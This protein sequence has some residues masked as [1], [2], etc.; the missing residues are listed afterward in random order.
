MASIKVKFRPSTIEGKKGVIYYQVIQNRIIRQL[1]TNYH[2]SPANWDEETFT[3][4]LDA[5]APNEELATIDKQ[6]QWDVKRLEAIIRL[7]EKKHQAYSS[8]D[9]I[10]FFQTRAKELSLFDYMHIQIEKQQQ[11]GR[12]RTAETYTTTLYSISRY[13]HQEDILM[14]EITSDLLQDYEDSLH[15]Q[16]VSQNSS[17]FY[18]R[19]L[20]AVY[21]RSVDSGIIEQKYPFKEV[22]TGIDKTV[23]KAIPLDMIK[24]I[25][26]LDFSNNPHLLFARD[27]FL[28]SFYT[29]GMS[30]IDMAYLRKEDLQDDTLIYSRRKTGHKLFVKWEPCMQEIIDRHPSDPE[31]PYMLPILKAPFDNER[32]Q[33]KTCLFLVNKNLK[34]VAAAA[35]IPIPL[36]MFVAR[37]SWAS[38]ASQKN[39]P[40]SIIS[41]GMGHES[42]QDTMIYLASLDNTLVDKANSQILDDL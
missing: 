35:G 39:I 26:A 40:L 32:N 6:V 36:T 3:F 7:F 41:E 38:I 42:E 33:Y 5:D 17:S 30:F 1:K 29:R 21:N 34:I 27:M 14:E 16:G 37:H 25:K 24:A 18:M 23:K 28:F 20:R 10:D 8:E 9:I 31:S 2:I 13:L 12:A 15:A 11:M 19:I 22:Y 4:K